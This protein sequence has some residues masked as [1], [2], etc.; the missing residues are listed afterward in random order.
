MALK[1]LYTGFKGRQMRYIFLYTLKHSDHDNKEGLLLQIN[2]FYSHL[3]ILPAGKAIATFNQTDGDKSI[4]LA[5][6]MKLMD[7]KTFSIMHEVTEENGETR[8]GEAIYV[9]DQQLFKIPIKPWG[10]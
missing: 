10:N 9:E 4:A 8:L 2:H 1:F 7:G 6:I 5:V 3:H